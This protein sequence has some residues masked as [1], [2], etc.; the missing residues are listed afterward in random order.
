MLVANNRP[1]QK[2]L[3][4]IKAWNLDLLCYHARV[5]S[6]RLLSYQLNVPGINI[7]EKEQTLPPNKDLESEAKIRYKMPF[8]DVSLLAIGLKLKIEVQH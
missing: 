1:T 5:L 7:F 6:Y 3:D 2:W 4:L 8:P